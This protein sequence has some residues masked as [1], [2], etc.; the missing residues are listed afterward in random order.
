MTARTYT[1]ISSGLLSERGKAQQFSQATLKQL[2]CQPKRTS[3]QNTETNKETNEKEGERER[4]K[5]I[6][7]DIPPH[8]PSW[9]HGIVEFPH[10]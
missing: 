9:N 5:Y 2:A 7:V 6:Y 3:K 10:G 1:W 4:Y 8:N